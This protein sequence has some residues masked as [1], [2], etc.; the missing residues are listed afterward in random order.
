QRRAALPSPRNLPI[1]TFVVLM[2]ENRSFDHFAGWF[3]GADGEQ[4][5]LSYVDDDGNTYQTH[6][7]A[8]D[9]QGGGFR[10]P[11]HPGGGGRAQLN[12]G[13]C[14]GFRKGV[15]DTYA[16]GYYGEQDI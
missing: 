9:D 5:G 14:D 10:A 13:R 2:M 8:P 16:I 12:G 11:V 4:T 1:D 15:N 6:P 7:L 3:P